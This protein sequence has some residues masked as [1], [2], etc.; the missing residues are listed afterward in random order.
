MAGGAVRP[1]RPRRSAAKKSAPKGGTHG[2]RADRRRP[3]RL[4]RLR[5]SGA[6]VPRGL[7]IPAGLRRARRRLRRQD[8]F[9]RAARARRQ[10]RRLFRGGR[11]G[12]QNAATALSGAPLVFSVVTA[13]QAEAAALAA[14]PGLARDAFFFDCNSCAPQ[15][16]AR[17]AERVEAAGGRYVDV[18]VM[19]P[20]HPRLHR[21]PLLISGP[22]AD[23]AAAALRSLDM[24]P[25]IH[26]GPVGSS[27]AIKMIRSVMIKGLEAL[28]CEC[29]LAGREAGV[30]AIVLASLDETFPGFDWKKRV[31]Y[32]LERMMTH[33]VRRAA[34]MREAALTVDQLGL[35]GAMSR[36][37]VAWQQRIGELALCAA[38]GDPSDYRD[39]ADRI[40]VGARIPTEKRNEDLRRRR[41]G[42][43]RRQTPGRARGHRRRR[44]RQRG[45]RQ[46]RRHRGA[47]RA[48][49]ASRTPTRASTKRWRAPM[50]R[51][52]F[53][54]RRPRCTPPRRSP[55]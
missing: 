52:S 55:A 9:P 23:A 45:R 25:K 49:A 2:D 46:V 39:L 27:S 50:S 35:D 3:H 47:R 29:A 40:L 42:R 30:D 6:G 20:V 26:E 18:A 12:R 19:S 36:G 17:S 43:V 28:A 10:A 44:G 15:T 41:R 1:R 34:E 51:R 11:R 32:M 54:R 21:S 13:D 37:A 8:R 22:H 33:G 38:D 48:S 24:A 4:S 16:K 5:R 7:A 14:L 53:C 31:A